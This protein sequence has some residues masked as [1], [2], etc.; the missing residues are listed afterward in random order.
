MATRVGLSER[1]LILSPKSKPRYGGAILIKLFWYNKITMNKPF[2]SFAELGK[3]V[4]QEKIQGLKQQIDNIFEKSI[5]DDFDSIPVGSFKS[6]LPE[7]NSIS[8]IRPTS[9]RGG[10]VLYAVIY[11]SDKEGRKI[12]HNWAVLRNGNIYPKDRI[13]SELGK[14]QQEEIAFEIAGLL[15]RINPAFIHLTDLDVIPLHDEGSEREPVQKT[16]GGGERPIDPER[17]Q[18][19]QSQRG[20]MFEF[21]NREIGFKG[22]KGL[23]F[24][25]FIYLENPFKD[26][27][28]FIVDLPEKIDIEAIEKELAVKAGEGVKVS[29]D[30]I[31][32]AVLKR[33]WQPIS[34]KAK[35]RKELVALGA[36]RFIHTPET[37]QDNIRQAIA[38][39]TK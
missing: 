27:A 28:A 11:S 13:P 32:E 12:S 9:E 30:D 3:T 19:L 8:F 1:P 17:E 16:D 37:W 23:V 35:T 36:Q 21:A 22:Y 33:Y 24:P 18:F 14:Y 34:E 15:E 6:N 39:R 4:K 29:K 25:T 2:K 5:K 10:D 38:E 26:N 7:I 20:A 31:R